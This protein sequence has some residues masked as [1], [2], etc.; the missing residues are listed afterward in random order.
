MK[1]YLARHGDYLT[2]PANQVG[3]LSAKGKKDIKDLGNF[4]KPYNIHVSAI[5]HSGKPR[6]EQTA[7]L[8]VSEIVCE[9]EIAARHGLNP[10]DDVSQLADD[11]V[12]SGVDVLLVGHLPLMGRLVAKLITGDE[13]KNIVVFQPGTLI[14]LEQIENQQWVI[15]WMWSPPEYSEALT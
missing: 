15:N 5:F 9:G 11:M 13:N 8:L 14:C 6:A 3:G 10:L 4:L 7:A 1:L 12:I 2:N